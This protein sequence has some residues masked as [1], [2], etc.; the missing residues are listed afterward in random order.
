MG[1][2]SIHAISRGRDMLAIPNVWDASENLIADAIADLLHLA[3]VST[4]DD[5]EGILPED[6]VER[7]LGAFRS[8]VG[9][10]DDLA[11]YTVEGE[12]ARRRDRLTTA[13]ANLELELVQR[14]LPSHDPLHSG[15]KS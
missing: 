9:Q 3:W 1:K 4:N 5:G 14:P 8:E 10:G 15:A 12:T 6:L 11:S 13:L 2:A 7:A